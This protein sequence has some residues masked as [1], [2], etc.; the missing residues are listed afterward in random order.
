MRTRPLL[1][2][3][4]AVPALLLG[5]TLAAALAP[6]PQPPGA[7]LAGGGGGAAP[8]SGGSGN[9]TGNE[10]QPPANETQPP[11]NET[12]PPQNETQPPTN[13]TAQP[14][15]APVVTPENQSVSGTAGVAVRF[16]VVVTNPATEAQNVSVTLSIP[17]GW[18]AGVAPF[19]PLLGP[20]ESVTLNG[21]VDSLL[22]GRGVVQVHVQGRD[23]ADVAYVDVC[24]RGLLQSCPTSGGNS[25][26]GTKPPANETKPPANETKPP[27]NETQP[28]SNG[29]KPRANETQAPGNDTAEAPAPAQATVGGPAL[30]APAEPVVLALRVKETASEAPAASAGDAAGPAAAGEA[31]AASV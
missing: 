14:L 16:E 1:L 28:P 19:D 11:K 25:T 4:L 26:N 5:A 6:I 15:P 31:L 22:P 21:S 24:F 13:E 27:A 29:T 12:K 23:G 17:L 18:R 10:T 8:L 30:G 3:T 9:D 20:G 2:L 7:S